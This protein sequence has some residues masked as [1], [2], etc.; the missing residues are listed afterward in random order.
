MYDIAFREK[1]IEKV[2]LADNSMEETG[3]RAMTLSF[4]RMKIFFDCFFNGN[5]NAQKAGITSSTLKD[6]ASVRAS[7][8]ETII[9]LGRETFVIRN[10]IFVTNCQSFSLLLSPPLDLGA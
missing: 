6:K 2:C 3:D 9:C 8:P 5:E 1:N 10:W 7:K 4:Q